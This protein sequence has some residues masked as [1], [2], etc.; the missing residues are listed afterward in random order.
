MSTLLLILK[1]G[2]E[3]NFELKKENEIFYLI[4]PEDEEVLRNALE[5]IIYNFATRIINYLSILTD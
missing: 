3:F 4:H 1:K 5:P 2:M